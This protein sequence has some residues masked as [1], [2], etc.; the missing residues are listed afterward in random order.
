MR[1]TIYMSFQLAIY[2][3]GSVLVADRDGNLWCGQSEGWVH[4]NSSHFKMTP[5][6]YAKRFDS[7][8]EAIEFAEV[9]CP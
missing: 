6:C 8:G 9:E 3:D 1:T 4:P 2:S 7:V 5:D